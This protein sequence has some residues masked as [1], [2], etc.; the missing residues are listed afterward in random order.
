MSVGW[1][2][3]ALGI[4]GAF[5][6]VL[7]TTPFLL[8]ALWAFTKS[9]PAAAAW[10]RAHAKLG[11]YITDWQDEGIIPL[12]AKILALAMMCA[13]FAWLALATDASAYVKIGVGVILLGAAAFISTRPS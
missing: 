12:R 3:V 8:V 6:P 1:V 9:S 13:S 4:A 11:P 7:P 10:L 5:L 2:F